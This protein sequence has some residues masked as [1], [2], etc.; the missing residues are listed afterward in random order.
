MSNKPSLFSSC[1]A[2]TMK[3]GAWGG[4]FSTD[5]YDSMIR[6]CIDNGITSFDHADLYGDY[7]TEEEF[8]KALKNDSSLRKR[9]QLI[10][11]C[12]I[13]KVSAKRPHHLIKSYNTSYS[14]IVSSAERS[15]LHFGTDYLDCLL[16][17]RPD[18]LLHAEEVAK[19]FT[20][21]KEKGMVLHFGVSN[22]SP[23]QLTMLH[24]YYPIEVNQVQCS[25]IHLSPFTD[26]TL[27]QCQMEKIIPMA[28]A[29]LGGGQ[30]ME[31]NGEERTWRILGA[32]DLLATNY[33]VSRELILLKWLQMHPSGILPVIG[34]SRKERITSFSSLTE[35]ELSREEWYMVWRASTGK[36][37]A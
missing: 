17:H 21:L 19:A 4:H 18:L 3:W 22:F 16:L 7:T 15:L 25:A 26:G 28:W 13:Q 23:M 33:R 32:A 20:Y 6:T 10:T 1:I 36:D 11:K 5:E 8:G 12:G 24:R 35:F 9:I 29:P 14:H 30:L 31:E 34:T 2:G 37:V 27:D